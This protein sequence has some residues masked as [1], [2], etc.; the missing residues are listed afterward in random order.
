MNSYN[1]HLHSPWH[2][3]YFVPLIPQFNDLHFIDEK[4]IVLYCA[5][6]HLQ[7]WCKMMMIS[8]WNLNLLLSNL[9]CVY[10][11]GS[12]EWVNEGEVS[13][14]VLFLYCKVKLVNPLYRIRKKLRLIFLFTVTLFRCLLY[15]RQHIYIFFFKH[16][17]LQ[18]NPIKSQS[19]SNVTLN[20]QKGSSSIIWDPPL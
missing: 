19:A 8:K 7:W 1:P 15:K 5:T 17:T 6:L 11:I 16:L 20:L 3:H 4:S 10:Y 18:L 13:D 2:V 14:T 12:S 9:F